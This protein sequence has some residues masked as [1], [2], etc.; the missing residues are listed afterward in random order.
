MNLAEQYPEACAKLIADGRPAIAEMAKHF[1]DA[2][3]MSLALGYDPSAAGHWLN[4]RKNASLPSN[5]NAAAWLL[6]NP[7]KPPE[8]PKPSEGTVL[9]CVC[10]PGKSASVQRML[11]MVGCEV[12]EV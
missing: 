4:G 12:V 10:P 5:A 7:P 9:M 6:A 8:P 1:T 3:T 2:R 11:A